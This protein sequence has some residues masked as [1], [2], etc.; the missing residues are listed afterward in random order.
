MREPF[1]HFVA[2][3]SWRA[4]RSTLHAPRSTL[5]GHGRRASDRAGGVWPGRSST[6]CRAEVDRRGL[7]CA[8]GLVTT[9]SAGRWAPP[10]RVAGAVTARAFWSVEA[11]SA[12]TPRDPWEGGYPA[13]SPHSAAGSERGLH[14]WPAA[15]CPTDR[16]RG[17]TCCEGVAGT[18]GRAAKMWAKARDVVDK[19]LGRHTG[20]RDD[21]YRVADPRSAVKRR[22]RCA[23]RD[24]TAWRWGRVGRDA[25]PWCVRALSRSRGALASERDPDWPAPATGA[26]RPWVPREVPLGG[27]LL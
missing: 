13:P 12:R 6:V 7:A 14:R 24:V 17:P 15:G 16:M 8:S 20:C 23:A 26:A 18:P 19:I 9:A 4:P 25:R 22:Y 5:R 1:D 3:R 27:N 2:S 10:G 21:A 11:C